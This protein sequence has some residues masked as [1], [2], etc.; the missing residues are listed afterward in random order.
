MEL[1]CSR[2]GFGNSTPKLKIYV[3]NNIIKSQTLTSN[4]FINGTLTPDNHSLVN[5]SR[6][7]L[8]DNYLTDDVFNL[9][10]FNNYFM[11]NRFYYK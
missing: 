4:L 9:Y 6:Q 1:W 5:S 3:R 11:C 7:D 10:F 2:F 8:Y